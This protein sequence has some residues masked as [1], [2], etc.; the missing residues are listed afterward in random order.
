MPQFDTI[1]KNGTVIDG[2]RVPRYRADIGIKSG[3][4]A[5]IG[6]LKTSQ[7]ASVIDASGYIVAPG[8]IDPAYPLRRADSLGRLLYDQ[9]LAWGNLGNDRELWLWLCA[10]PRPRC[11]TGHAGPVAQRGHSA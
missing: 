9:Q 6:N 10:A 7:A 4:I 11:R 5:A 8:F 3:L 2:T 1:I